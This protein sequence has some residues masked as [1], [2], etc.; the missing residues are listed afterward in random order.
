M[1]VKPNRSTASVKRPCG[2][3]G[4][5]R[6]KDSSQKWEE[7]LLIEDDITVDAL[8]LRGIISDEVKKAIANAARQKGCSIKTMLKTINAWSKAEKAELD[9]PAKAASK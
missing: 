6:C 5:Y 9:A 7:A 8:Y 4:K 3:K 2:R 1:R